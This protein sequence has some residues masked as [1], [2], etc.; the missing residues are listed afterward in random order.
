MTD[1]SAYFEYLT[2]R[3]D[4]G[5]SKNIV[6]STTV[7]TIVKLLKDKKKLQVLDVGCFSGAMLNRIYQ[8]LP[9]D[10]RNRVHLTGIDSDKEAMRYGAKKYK[11]IAFFEANL[12]EKISL[13]N[14][15][16]VV[17]LCNVL[18][19]LFPNKSIEVR[20]DKIKKIYKQISDL[21]VEGGVLILLDGVKPDDSGRKIEIELVSREWGDKYEKLVNEYMAIKLEGKRLSD[22]KIM[23][24]IFSLSV[25]LTKVRYLDKE[26]WK[27]EATQLYQYFSKNDF[28][29]MVEDAKM[30]LVMAEPQYLDKK[31][32]SEM[33]KSI[34][35]EVDYPA[36]NILVVAMK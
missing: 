13:V 27:N 32:V 8:E 19:E 34:P 30:K 4:S 24:N 17:I 36:K 35:T 14:R 9:N 16:D 5:E 26:Y 1:R 25:F 3:L 31:L 28:E 22:K 23:T 6:I 11:N 33:I 29:D 12:E 21:L 15:F 7:E 2:R 10:L 20:K 18:H